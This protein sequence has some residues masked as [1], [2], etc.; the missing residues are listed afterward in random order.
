MN[1][2]NST[3]STMIVQNVTIKDKDS[4][5]TEY[6]SRNRIVATWL[7]RVPQTSRSLSV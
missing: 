1:L 2:S 3:I 6:S 5:M 4:S 7:L